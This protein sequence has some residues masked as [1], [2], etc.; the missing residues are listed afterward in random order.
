MSLPD[1]LEAA[2][3][4]CESWADEHSDRDGFDCSGCG[5]RTSWVEAETMSVD[6]YAL[7]VCGECFNKE[8]MVHG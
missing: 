7:P 2:E 5:K 4:R 6:P 3:N 1:P 8:F